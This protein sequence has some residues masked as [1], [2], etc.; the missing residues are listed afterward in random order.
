[1]R[2][3]LVAAA[4][5]LA[6]QISSTPEIGSDPSPQSGRQDEQLDQTRLLV[7]A[8][9]GS[10]QFRTIQA[11]LET[12]SRDNQT[13]KTVLVKNG[14]YREKIFITPSHVAVVGED[15]DKTVIEFAE[16]RKNWRA[17]HPDD[18]GAAV[19]NIGDTATD[20]F[21]G[22]LTVHNTYGSLHGDHDHQFAVRSGGIATR[23]TIVHAKI[24]ADGG[25]TLSLWNTGNGMY[26]HADC[27]FEGWVDYVCPRGWCYITNS[28]FFG[29][30]LTASI[31]H[32]GSKDQ[33]QKLVIRRSSFDGVPGFPLGR[34]NR[35]GQFYLL[36]NRFSASMADK[37]IYRPSADT[38]YQWPIRNYFWNNRRDDGNFAW[39][40]DN[41]RQAPGG[42]RPRDIT[43]GWTFQGRWHPEEMMPP[44]M[45]FTSTPR[46]EHGD[47]DVPRTLAALRWAGARGAIRYKVSFGTQTPPPARGEV[48]GTTFRLPRLTAGATYYWRVDTV[49]SS[50][51]VA[52]PVWSFG[53]EPGPTEFAGRTPGAIPTPV[54]AAPRTAV[55][56]GGVTWRI[57]IVLVG[58]STVTDESGWGGGFKLRVAD[59]A[60][61]INLARNGRSSKSFIAEG[62]WAKALEARA[63]YV[64]IQFGHNDMAGKG[65]D[66]ETDPK[67][68]YR[69]YLAR[70][71]D[72]SRAAG[73]TPI[74][75]TSLTRRLF[76]PDGKIHSDLGDCV[77]AAKAVALEKGVALIDLHAESI[78]VLD[79]M[80]AGAAA[81]FNI[82]NADGTPD[83]THL[84]TQGSTAFGA[85]VADELL[86]LVPALAP[87]L[88]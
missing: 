33:E 17:T 80:G 61:C 21:L 25:D 57:R 77:A 28:R 13:L 26:Y 42:P 64:L 43:P 85:I 44:V 72:E 53:V 56:G 1:M 3:I 71:V 82:A 84:S 86:K 70:Y 65:S 14:T 40:A 38:A 60:D 16:L 7:V 35:D 18:W 20:I 46:P 39:F 66:R 58:D 48:T 79:R 22:N 23:I 67:T 5:A 68:T 32:D 8:Q 24:I 78:D 4:A 19:V 88:K 12:I 73:A 69:T 34:N 10:G 74:I 87:Y 31:W 76:G 11:A 62:H 9:D 52:G 55:L 49:T 15:R 75:V 81:A 50:G 45:P 47:R 30:N 29:H 63:D 54:G 6:A 83:T 59:R 36:D 2:L 37:P 51:I 41:L 27:D